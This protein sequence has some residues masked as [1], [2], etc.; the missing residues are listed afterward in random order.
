[1]NAPSEKKCPHCGIRFSWDG[2][3]WLMANAH[4]HLSRS[5][6]AGGTLQPEPEIRRC[7]NCGRPL[8]IGAAR[9]EEVGE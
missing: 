4:G 5:S 1:M 2:T 8:Q 3:A 9:V 7:P 6:V